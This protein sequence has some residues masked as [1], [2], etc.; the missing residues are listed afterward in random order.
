M[1]IEDFLYHSN[2]IQEELKKIL[3]NRKESIPAVGRKKERKSKS[4]SNS[5]Q[6]PPIK[7]T[8]LG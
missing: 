2:V 4:F 7:G 1:I 6:A 8:P 5:Y 3:V